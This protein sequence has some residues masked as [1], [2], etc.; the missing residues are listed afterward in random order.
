[1]E[2]IVSKK[3]KE[4]TEGASASGAVKRIFREIRDIPYAVVPEL[5][6]LKKGPA[7]MLSLNK[8]FC[9][10]KHY[11]MGMMYEKLGVDVTYC[12]FEFYWKDMDVDYPPGLR[13]LTEG[14]P[15]TYHLACGVM[16]GGRRVL[17]DATWDVSLKKAGFPVNVKWDGKSDTA[18]AVK[19][20]GK[21]VHEDADERDRVFEKK[22]ADYSLA[23]KL[24]LYRFSRELNVW[25]EDLR[26]S[27]K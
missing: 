1:M 9:V 13:K 14:L 21:F 5:F 2:K 25:L 7:G 11:L 10:P 23:E 27:G 24:M 6:S 17:A 3:F 18:C 4:W 15:A 26:R 8:G 22:M 12:T 16:A 19:P 20:L